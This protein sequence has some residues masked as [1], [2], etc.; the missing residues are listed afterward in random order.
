MAGSYESI[1]SFIVDSPRVFVTLMFGTVKALA[2]ALLPA[3]YGIKG[4]F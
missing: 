1:D 2:I 4:R 3:P